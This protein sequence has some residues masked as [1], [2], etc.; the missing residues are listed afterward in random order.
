M[1]RDH[2][3]SMTSN[4]QKT[5]SSSCGR[6][7]GRQPARQLTQGEIDDLLARVLLVFA[8]RGQELHRLHGTKQLQNDT[9]SSDE[10]IATATTPKQ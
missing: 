1:D 8:K 9:P 5:S 6:F 3:K 7:W 10:R 2:R 4:S